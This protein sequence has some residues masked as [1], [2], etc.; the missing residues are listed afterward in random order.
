MKF[1]VGDKIKLINCGAISNKQ[2]TITR[3]EPDRY[4]DM[5]YE[6]ATGYWFYCSKRKRQHVTSIR[7]AKLVTPL[8]QIL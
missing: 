7:Y 4:R 3:L 2:Y 6:D 5:G 1:K 8:E